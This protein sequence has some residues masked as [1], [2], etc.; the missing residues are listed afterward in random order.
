MVPARGAPK[1][2]RRSAK[3][4]GPSTLERNVADLQLSTAQVNRFHLEAIAW[5]EQITA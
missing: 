4:P 5:A 1:C 2:W 3:R